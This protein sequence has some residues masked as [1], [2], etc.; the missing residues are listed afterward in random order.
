[1]ASGKVKNPETQIFQIFFLEGSQVV[2]YCE[3]Q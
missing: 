2:Q 1:M 3:W